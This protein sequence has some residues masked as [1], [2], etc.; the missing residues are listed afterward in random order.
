MYVSFAVGEVYHPNASLGDLLRPLK[1][2]ALFFP[3]IVIVFVFLLWL[4]RWPLSDK[5]YEIGLVLLIV[6]MIL[7]WFPRIDS[8]FRQEYWL[9]QTPHEIPWQYSPFNGS[10][11]PG[12]RSFLVRV[13]LPDL[14]PEYETSEPTVIIGKAVDFNHGKGGAVPENTCIK[15]RDNARC[16]WR[17]GEFVYS[18]SGSSKAIPP[19]LR[20]YMDSIANLLDGFE[21]TEPE[22]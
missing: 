1:E 14:L 21:I 8:G 12:G 4:W 11:K 5:P 10:K 3:I 15:D 22:T 19:D 16:E 2:A 17:R 13:A 18:A 9:A 20:S 6:A 7:P